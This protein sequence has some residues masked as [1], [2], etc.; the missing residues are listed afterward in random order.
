[1]SN[2]LIVGWSHTP[3]GKH[4]GKDAEA[5]IADVAGAAIA[6][7][8]LEPGD[9]DAVFIGMFNNGMAKQDFPA[10]L[11]LQSLPELR[12]KPMARCEN[13]CASGSAAIH[14]GRNFIR[15]GDGR[16]VLVIGAEKMTGGTTAS[17][18]DA[19]LG[20][21]YRREENEIKAGFAGVFARIAEAYFQHYG[22]QEPSQWCR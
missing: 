13:A 8:G 15:S 9:I 18:G 11:V 7:A 20:A 4:E 16:T 19:L 17:V 12:Y 10:S 1:M 2:P 3:F 6:D 14:A 21:S 22:D 5:L